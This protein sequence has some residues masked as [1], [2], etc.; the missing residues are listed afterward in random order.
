[1]T[2]RILGALAALGLTACYPFGM[3]GSH[4]Q[5]TDRHPLA[6]HEPALVNPQGEAMAWQAGQ[7]WASTVGNPA[8]TILRTY[9]QGDRDWNIDRNENTGII[10]DRYMRVAVL[11]KGGN[12][13][14]CR[15]W[16]CE[17]TEEEAGGTWGRPQMSCPNGAVIAV[18]CDSITALR[19]SPP[20]Q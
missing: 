2:A 1:M 9:I 10:T 5:G 15:Q 16:D 13:G 4:E 6:A 7:E 8:P 14:K 11:Y 17:L 12:S 19:A 20:P 3:M 18:T